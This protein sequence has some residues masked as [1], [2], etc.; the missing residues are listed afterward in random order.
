MLLKYLSTSWHLG[1]PLEIILILSTPKGWKPELT[2]KKNTILYN[3]LIL[4][5]IASESVAW[6]GDDE[7]HVLPYA[8][9]KI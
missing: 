6:D 5:Y 9:E 2:D 3:Y 1:G 7:A 8:Q 4:P